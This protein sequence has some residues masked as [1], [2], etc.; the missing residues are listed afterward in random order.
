MAN[1][2]LVATPL[3]D[4]WTTEPFE[5]RYYAEDMA[6]VPGLLVKPFFRT[7]PDA[8]VRPH[9]SAEVVE[10]VRQA[11]TSNLAVVPRAAA[12]TALFQSVPLQ[13]GLVI[14]LNGLAG[15]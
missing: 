15:R 2:S 6:P 12:S 14:D 3:G 11:I 1:T 5:R 10:A 13:G 4:R 9:T 8:V 7:L